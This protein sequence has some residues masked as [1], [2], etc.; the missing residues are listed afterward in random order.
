MNKA[1]A[2]SDSR[3]KFKP[4][5][6]SVLGEEAAE[7]DYDKELRILE[8]AH[9]VIYDRKNLNLKSPVIKVRGFI[10][11]TSVKEMIDTMAEP[12]LDRI[13]HMQTEIDAF[14]AELLGV[15]SHVRQTRADVAMFT[16]RTRDM[17]D[18]S[19]ALANFRQDLDAQ[20]IRQR[21]RADEL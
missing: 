9:R 2:L 3:M 6:E 10:S 1:R 16:S 18:F 19:R 15:S 21:G 14:R 12:I 8:E 5:L 20:T 11:Y 17:A 4:A 13:P 7:L